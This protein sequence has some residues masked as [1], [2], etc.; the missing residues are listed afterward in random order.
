MGFI[1]SY[2]KSKSVEE[3]VAEKSAGMSD[4]EKAQYWYELT[5]NIFALLGNVDVAIFEILPQEKK[6]KMGSTLFFA[7]PTSAPNY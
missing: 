4:A 3:I 6:T 2:L 5:Q 1:C 7:V